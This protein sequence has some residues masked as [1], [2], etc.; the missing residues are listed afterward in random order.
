MDWLK[1]KAKLYAAS[2]KLNSAKKIKIVS[3]WGDGRWYSKPMAPKKA[4]IA[5]LISGKIN[6][7]LKEVTRDKDG[8]YIMIKETIQE[9]IMDMCVCVS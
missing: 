1:N 2:G 7:K 8:Q 4:G 6:F 3:K 9:N 5:I